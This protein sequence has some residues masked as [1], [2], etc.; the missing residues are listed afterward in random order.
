MGQGAKEVNERCNR[1][2]DYGP[3]SSLAEKDHPEPTGLFSIRGRID[4]K[5]PKW[6]LHSSG[7]GGR[8]Y[9]ITPNPEDG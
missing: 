6:P 4:E 8:E 7:E 3:F 5:G 2:F 9:L 1:S